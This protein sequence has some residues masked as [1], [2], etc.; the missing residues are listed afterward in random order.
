LILQL[1]FIDWFD[2]RI[3]WLQRR[4][5]TWPEWV[6]AYFSFILLFDLIPLLFT[7][8]TALLLVW[9]LEGMAGWQLQFSF[10]ACT[11]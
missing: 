3:S 5:N 1:V 2:N 7:L 6:D 10:F 9:W 11:L 8:H 4:K